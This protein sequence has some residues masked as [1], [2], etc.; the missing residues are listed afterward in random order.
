MRI[1]TA[2]DMDVM[3]V[4]GALHLRFGPQMIELTRDETG[5][6]LAALD[7]VLADETDGGGGDDGE[8]VVQLRTVG[9]DA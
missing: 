4:D 8:R 5:A 6:F 3:M 7:A 2:D 9:K 1:S